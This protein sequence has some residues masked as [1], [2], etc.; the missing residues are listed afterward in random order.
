[1]KD[2]G[3]Q[4]QKVAGS[5]PAEVVE[6][7]RPGPRHAPAVDIFEGG[8]AITLLADMPG[9]R[10]EDLRI[11][12]REGTLTLEGEVRDLR[13][14]GAVEVLREYARGTYF[15]QFRLAETID[16]EHIDA[17]LTDGVLTLVLPKTKAPAPRRIAVQSA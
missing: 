14:E 8:D 4:L 1:M 11:D 16:Q 12:L 13:P 9:V 7:T 2:N 5:E 6:G 17:K 10:S 15:R 3:E